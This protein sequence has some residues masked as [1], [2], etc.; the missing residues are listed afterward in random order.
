[1]RR[2]LRSQQPTRREGLIKALLH[3]IVGKIGEIH[4]ESLHVCPDTI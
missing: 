4:Y 2:Q 3:Q 1:M